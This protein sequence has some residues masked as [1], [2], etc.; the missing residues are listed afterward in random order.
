[1]QGRMAALALGLV[2]SCAADARAQDAQ[3]W[4]K[5]KWGPN[6]EKGAANLL[7]PQL[8]LDAAKQFKPLHWSVQLRW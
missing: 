4:C 7:T 1:M 8:A 3:S 6:D 2:I 5:S